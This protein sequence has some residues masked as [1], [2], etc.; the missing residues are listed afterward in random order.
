MD[1]VHEAQIR[2][3]CRR[4]LLELDLLLSAFVANHFQRLSRDD[5]ETFGRLLELPDPSLLDILLNGAEPPDLP[6]ISAVLD[7]I[8]GSSA[9]RP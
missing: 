8:R 2:W 9:L 1:Q 7:R 3:R 4:G 5:Q 6:G